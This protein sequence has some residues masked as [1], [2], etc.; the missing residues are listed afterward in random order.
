MDAKHEELVARV[1]CHSG[2][3]KAAK[4]CLV[5]IQYCA[6]TENQATLQLSVGSGAR[7]KKAQGV[8]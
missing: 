5:G 3:S 1:G 8:C 7:N 2:I 6:I 4:L